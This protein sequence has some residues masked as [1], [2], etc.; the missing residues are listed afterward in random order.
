MF[1]HIS[2]HVFLTLF[3]V[4]DKSTTTNRT[5]S[6]VRSNFS[7]RMIINF[8]RRL[9]RKKIILKRLMF[10]CRPEHHYQEIK[11]NKVVKDREHFHSGLIG[12]QS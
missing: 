12:V 5:R 8:T 7:F 9:K 10:R 2:K 3:S 4:S 6:L 11:V 1:Y